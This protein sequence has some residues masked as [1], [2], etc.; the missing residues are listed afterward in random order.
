M[1][2]EVKSHWPLRSKTLN[3]S[4]CTKSSWVVQERPLRNPWWESCLKLTTWLC[5][6]LYTILSWHLPVI[7]KREMALYTARCAL[8]QG[9]GNNRN[10]LSGTAR[11][12]YQEESPE[13]VSKDLWSPKVSIAHHSQGKDALPRSVYT[14]NSMGPRTIE[15]HVYDEQVIR[16]CYECKRFQVAALPNPP[17]GH[18]PKNI[19]AASVPFKS[20]G[21]DF[22]DQLNTSARPKRKWRLTLFFMHVVSTERSIWTCYRARALT[23][24]WAA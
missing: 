17:T 16:S 6:A 1:T 19:T 8:E 9:H 2:K 5:I 18:I 7:V 4:W 21:V 20:L 14:A 3:Q 11:E 23:S 13:E 15:C 24:S 22:A 12:R 10:H